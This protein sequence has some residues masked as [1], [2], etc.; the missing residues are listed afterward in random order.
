MKVFQPDCWDR[1]PEVPSYYSE[2][3]LAQAVTIGAPF[4]SFT[5]IN[6]HL[7]LTYEQRVRQLEE[8]GS[9]AADRK[10]DGP[11]VL[12][13]DL[14]SQPD[15]PSLW[16][17]RKQLRD[18][19]LFHTSEN[20]LTSHM[21]IGDRLTFPSD[22]PARCIDYIFVSGEDFDVLSTEIPATT[23]SDHLPVVARLTLQ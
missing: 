8:I 14:N 19:Y 6:T 4:G 16:P 7:G 15:V 23:L 11:V 13:G 5:A 12:G 20:H 18:V 22:D 1:E 2:Q 21:D 10:A 9:I 17:L 3:R